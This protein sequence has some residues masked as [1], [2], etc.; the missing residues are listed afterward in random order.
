MCNLSYIRSLLRHSDLCSL[1]LKV[2]MLSQ[3]WASE[4]SLSFCVAFLAVLLGPGR[5]WI[6]ALLLPTTKITY[7]VCFLLQIFCKALEQL[8]IVP[9]L[10]SYLPSFLHFRGDRVDRKLEMWVSWLEFKVPLS[11][12]LHEWAYNS[13]NQ[14]MSLP[15]LKFFNDFP[16]HLKLDLNS[17]PWSARFAWSRCCLLPQLQHVPH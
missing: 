15:W 13:V 10:S 1:Q 5:S 14:I 11:K 3:S 16:L 2:L 17:F 12:N 6:P 8:H 4:L 7:S 9:P